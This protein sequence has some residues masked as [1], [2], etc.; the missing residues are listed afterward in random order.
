MNYRPDMYAEHQRFVSVGF[1][2]LLTSK[3]VH[4]QARR[5]LDFTISGFLV[6]DNKTS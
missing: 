4:W 6:G 1:Q 2:V 3:T 5:W